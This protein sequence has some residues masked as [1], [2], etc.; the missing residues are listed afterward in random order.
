M[1]NNET[2]DSVKL[3]GHIFMDATPGDNVFKL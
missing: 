2:L 3:D 1:D